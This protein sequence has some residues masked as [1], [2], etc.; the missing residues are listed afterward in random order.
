MICA[1]VTETQL[2]KP[3]EQLR[4]L[5]REGTSVVKESQRAGG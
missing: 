2:L 5:E 1:S 3:A 4:F